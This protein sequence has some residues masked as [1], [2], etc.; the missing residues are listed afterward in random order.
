MPG[1]YSS[2]RHGGRATYL[3]YMHTH[4]HHT[5]LC[6]ARTYNAAMGSFPLRGSPREPGRV[7]GRARGDGRQHRKVAGGRT[8]RRAALHLLLLLLARQ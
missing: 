8:P 4:T 5:T 3:D 6:R 1:T 2:S 7:G